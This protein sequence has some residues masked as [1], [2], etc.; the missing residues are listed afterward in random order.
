MTQVGHL[1]KMIWP[2][3]QKQDSSY[4]IYARPNRPVYGVRLHTA[5]QR[6]PRIAHGPF[7]GEL[8]FDPA[9]GPLMPIPNGIPTL[10]HP[11]F[12]V[13]IA[14]MIPQYTKT[15]DLTPGGRLAKTL[16]HYAGSSMAAD[17]KKLE[18][19]Y[20]G[21]TALDAPPFFPPDGSYPPGSMPMQP[22]GQV[23]IGQLDVA[24]ALIKGGCRC[25]LPGCGRVL[26]FF[27]VDHF[28]ANHPT[29]ARVEHLE[30]HVGIRGATHA[31]N[32]IHPFFVCHHCHSKSRI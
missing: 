31:A 25:P 26:D 27:S 6:Q 12:N 14:R 24:F 8:F 30:P 5:I 28:A 10:P 9:S 18:R 1:I 22:P 17:G 29:L 2:G 15:T 20:T 19:W 16:S 21:A 13:D 23:P 7:Q 11:P 32:N 3:Y 4:I